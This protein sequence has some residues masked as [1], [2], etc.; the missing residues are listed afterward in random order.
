M[1][2]LKEYH[3]K[4]HLKFQNI[5]LKIYTKETDYQKCVPD[6]NIPE[7]QILPFP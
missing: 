1:F 6:V 5:L 2:W 7:V 4:F 3:I